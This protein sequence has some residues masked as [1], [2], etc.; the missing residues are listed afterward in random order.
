MQGHSKSKETD[1]TGVLVVAFVLLLGILFIRFT[2]S[3]TQISTSTSTKA[4]E[5]EAARDNNYCNEGSLL[6]SSIYL[7]D[8]YCPSANV[9]KWFIGKGTITG[10]CVPGYIKDKTSLC[11]KSQIYGCCRKQ[12]QANI[13]L[14]GSELC[15]KNHG[16]SATCNK[17]CPSGTTKLTTT[18]YGECGYINSST[19]FYKDGVCCTLP[20]PAATPTSFQPNMS[21]TYVLY[22]GFP[23]FGVNCVQTIEKA[24]TY[25]QSIK[26]ILG[27]VENTDKKGT[28]QCGYAVSQTEVCD[29]KQ[30]FYGLYYDGKLVKSA[31]YIGKY[32][33]IPVIGVDGR[34]YCTFD[35]VSYSETDCLS[36]FK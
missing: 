34:Y 25:M 12:V 11:G 28:F 29:G 32:Q 2:S 14:I 36:M 18:K 15:T 27:V 17:S 23:N 6:G 20:G 22:K 31:C 35:E 33:Q 1:I 10:K 7:G 8:D 16:V 3:L 4:T 24:P 5:N 9:L 21:S 19:E 26:N 13:S 30:S